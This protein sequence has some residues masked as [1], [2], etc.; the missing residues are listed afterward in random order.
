M[1]EG[2][3]NDP[4]R[5]DKKLLRIGQQVKMKRMNRINSIPMRKINVQTQCHYIKGSKDSSD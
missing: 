5:L 4:I 2:W 1:G 3:S